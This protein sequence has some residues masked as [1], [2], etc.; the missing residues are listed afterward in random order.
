VTAVRAPEFSDGFDRGRLDPDRWIAAYLPQ[1]SSRAQSAPAFTFEDGGLVLEVRPGQQPW[2][3]EWDGD[4]RVSSIQTGVFAGPLGS[5]IGQHR[6]APD[7]VVREEQAERRLYTPRLGRIEIR[8]AASDAPDTMVALWMIG[9]EDAPDD[10]GEICVVEIFSRDVG[11]DRVAIG[12]G[13]H[14]HRDP[15]LSDD[16]TRVPVAI[17]ATESHEYAVE[18]T[19][20]GIT[21]EVDGRVVRSSSQSPG[22]PMQLMLGIYAFGPVAAGGAA[23]RFVVEHVRGY[24]PAGGRA[25]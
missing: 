8:A 9:F 19:A 2:C 5:A 21:W 6:F 3:P 13:V 23:R 11:P 7:V 4:L 10:C 24:P 12:M 20:G 15:R 16:F 25:A 1:W 22:Y 14:P 17:D 18:W